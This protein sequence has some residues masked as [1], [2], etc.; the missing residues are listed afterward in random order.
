LRAKPD[1]IKKQIAF[2]TSLAITAVIFV[3]WIVSLTVQADSGIATTD[4]TPSARVASPLSALSANVSDAFT[5]LK[6]MIFG[7]PVAPKVGAG[8]EALPGNR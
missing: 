7:S 3:F 2:F 5:G 4:G 1:H 6:N 8:I